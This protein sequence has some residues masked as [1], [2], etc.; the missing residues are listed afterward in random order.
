MI[1]TSDMTLSVIFSSNTITTPFRVN[2]GT[3]TELFYN[4]L[5]PATD[6]MSISIP[7]SRELATALVA[8]V[9]DDNKVV[10]TKEGDRKS[11]RLNSSHL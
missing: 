5:K 10:I 6:S 2:D 3:W 11:T 7:W 1:D 9:D 4:D 8:S